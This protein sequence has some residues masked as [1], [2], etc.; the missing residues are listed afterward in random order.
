MKEEI[1]AV[2]I[3]MRINTQGWV[4]RNLAGLDV[5]EDVFVRFRMIPPQTLGEYIASVVADET[6][7]L[8]SRMSVVES[9]LIGS[10]E[11]VRFQSLI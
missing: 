7:D 10:T 9:I 4:K 1:V 6:E 2:V 11:H 8:D 5:D 3:E